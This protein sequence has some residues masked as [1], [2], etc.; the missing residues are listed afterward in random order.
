MWKF[1]LALVLSAAANG[2]AQVLLK[3]GVTDV[4]SD[5]KSL[6]ENLLGGLASG[7]IWIGVGIMA[8]SLVAYLYSF[9]KIDVSRAAPV[10]TGLGIVVIALIGDWWLG[11]RVRVDQW[12]GF[13]AI[14]LGIWL[15]VRSEPFQSA[16]AQ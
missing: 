14:V 11:E 13:A 4:W 5:Q 2:A 6:G 12:I 10:A 16:V 9:A 15:V 8:A 7:T 3:K 1:Y